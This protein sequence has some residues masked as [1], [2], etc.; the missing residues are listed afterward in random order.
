MNGLV[1]LVEVADDKRFVEQ[2]VLPRLHTWSQKLVR[3]YSQIGNRGLAT[4]VQGFTRS[5][6]DYLI[7]GDKDA[8]PCIS[9]RKSSLAER[10]GGVPQDRIIVVERT[11]ER[12]IEAWYLAGLS[13]NNRLRI[14]V[15]RDIDLYNKQRFVQL[16][17]P[18]LGKSGGSI[19]EIKIQILE[20]YDREFALNRSR[21]LQYFA[22][23][24]GIGAVQSEH[25]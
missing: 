24:L 2:I 12:T 18:I 15:P 23:R 11:V 21:S 13:P 25:L 4:I 8:Y 19:V 6:W 3:E 7:L 22:S 9:Q 16:I 20:E 17:Q 5:G 14:E 10:F 1:I